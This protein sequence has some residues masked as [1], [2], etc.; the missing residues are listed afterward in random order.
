MLRQS[1]RTAIIAAAA[2]L[3]GVLFAA[4]SAS[5][6]GGLRPIT[7]DAAR[8]V[9]LIRPLQ[10]VSGTP[11][12][13][14]SSHADFTSQ[15]R[16]LA[17][18]IVRTHDVDCKGT[19]DIDG[20]GPNRI[21]PDWTA[22]PN[23]PRSYNFAPTDQA[24]LSIVR[25]GAAGRVQRRAQRPE[26]RRHRRQQRAAARPGAVRER[27]PHVAQ[28]YNDGWDNGYRLAHPLLGDLERAGPHAVLVG[29]AAQFYALYAAT[30]AGAQVAAPVDAGRRPGAHHQQR[31]DRLPRVAAQLHPRQPAAARLLVD[32]QVHG[33]LR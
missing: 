33:L 19:S 12:P 14:D 23:D 26:L 9:G 21:F 27:R 13:G 2:V 1:T 11:L 15:F 24:I 25:E 22:D 18:N 6:A 31:P 29:H 10:G 3:V 32:P 16:Q 28:H 4:A 5:A 8:P 7:V 20:I 17:V 30:R